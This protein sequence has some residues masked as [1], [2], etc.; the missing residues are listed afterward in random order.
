MVSWR[1]WFPGVGAIADA[2]AAKIR[3]CIKN[4]WKVDPSVVKDIQ[5]S[6]TAGSKVS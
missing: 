5:S 4:E 3:E 1:K 2:L 6:V